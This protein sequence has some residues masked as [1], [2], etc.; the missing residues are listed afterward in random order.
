MWPFTNVPLLVRGYRSYLSRLDHDNLFDV[1]IKMMYFL[2]LNLVMIQFELKFNQC[3]SNGFG[4]VFD[5]HKL[6]ICVEGSKDTWYSHL[7]WS[8]SSCRL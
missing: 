3:S 2:R 6:V 8:N 5:S 7:S 4:R 1:R